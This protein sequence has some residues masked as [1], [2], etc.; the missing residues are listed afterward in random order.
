MLKEV[1]S[2][3]EQWN[4]F[5]NKITNLQGDLAQ[6]QVDFLDRNSFGDFVDNLWRST[7]QNYPEICMT[8]YFSETIREKLEC[9]V[10]GN[11][12]VR[13]II[14]EVTFKTF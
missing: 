12:N 4:K 3:G 10:S 6:F 2:M 14:P 7:L 9:L 8:G 11:T 13:L 5:I 1:V